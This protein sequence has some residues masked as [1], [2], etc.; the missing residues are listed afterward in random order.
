MK[1]EKQQGVREVHVIT[2]L[3]ETVRPMYPSAADGPESQAAT[4]DHGKHLGTCNRLKTDAHRQLPSFKPW[5]WERL[6]AGGEGA[7]GG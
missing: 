4:R 5:C 2:S 1:R 7:D 6:R 3:G